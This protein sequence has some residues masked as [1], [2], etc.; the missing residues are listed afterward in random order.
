MP[1]GTIY[2][3]YSRGGDSF[4]VTCAG[5]GNAIILKS[6]VATEDNDDEMLA[7]MQQA[8]PV[9]GGKTRLLERLCSGQTLLCRALGL[10][11]TDWNMKNF[12]AER[13]FIECV[14][15]IPE[16]IAIAPRL[17]IPK[18]RDEHL[19]LRFIDEKYIKSST[20]GRV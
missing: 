13:L 14:G 6:A 8:N 9:K 15:Y 20:N 16:K 10:K 4:N 3:Y 19:L 12:A 5:E 1:A 17:G 11:V 2:M 18:G 7:I